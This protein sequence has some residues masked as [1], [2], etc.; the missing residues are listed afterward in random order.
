MN[1]CSTAPGRKPGLRTGWCTLCNPCS[2]L[3]AAETQTGNQRDVPAA[4]TGV[5]E[6]PSPGMSLASPGQCQGGEAKSQAVVWG[7]SGFSFSSCSPLDC[8]GTDTRTTFTASSCITCP[9]LW[10][11]SPTLPTWV[12]PATHKA[13]HWCHPSILPL[14]DHFQSLRKIPRCSH[15]S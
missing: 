9:C 12:Q 8:K 7:S 11:L 5:T 10:Y 1:R 13:P 14:N 6:L 4:H 2:S 15:L 3:T